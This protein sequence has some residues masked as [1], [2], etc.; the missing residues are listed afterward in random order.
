MLQLHL[1]EQPMAIIRSLHIQQAGLVLLHG[2]GEGVAASDSEGAVASDEE[3]AFGGS[4]SHGLLIRLMVLSSGDIM[5]IED[6]KTK[7][8]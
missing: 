6:R 4:D 5:K 8:N 1:L 7:R 3:E 2:V